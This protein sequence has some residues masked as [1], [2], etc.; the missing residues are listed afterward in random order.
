MIE[1]EEPR[2]AGEVE[3]EQ[4]APLR[5]F[6]GEEVVDY[7][8][9][10][11]R[12]TAERAPFWRAKLDDERRRVLASGGKARQPSEVEAI[13]L[14]LEPVLASE[15]SMLADPAAMVEQDDD[16]FADLFSPRTR[17]EYE[18]RWAAEDAR[19]A[20][21]SARD[22]AEREQRIAASALTDDEYLRLF[23]DERT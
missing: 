23:R 21:E 14:G 17:E 5:R 10:S 15:G 3:P 13:I 9:R 22:R 11:G 8:V 7:A 18:R 2:P 6:V 4:P 1:D 16:E 12:F 19:L 20:A